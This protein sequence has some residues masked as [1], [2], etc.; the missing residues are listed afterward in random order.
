MWD[1]EMKQKAREA[2]HYW[3]GTPHAHWMRQRGIGV[4][5]IHFVV[6][7]LERA[8]AIG[9]AEIPRYSP[10]IGFR[11]AEQ[12]L[13]KEFSDR[14]P[15]DLVKQPFQFGDIVIFDPK[16]STNHVALFI[17]GMLWHALAGQAVNVYPFDDFRRTA[18]GAMR[19]K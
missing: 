19:L 6:D 7:V 8:G 1:E 11:G 3:Q 13:I 15:L 16:L 4:D 2:C 14:V 12:K 5:C 9:P 18:R 10:N 17:D